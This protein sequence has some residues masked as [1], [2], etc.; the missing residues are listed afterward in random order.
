M[1]WQEKA[2]QEALTWCRTPY[3]SR[4]RIKGVGVDCGQILIAVYEAAGVLQPGECE[5]GDYIHDRHEH[6]TE[7]NYLEWITRY[8]EPI[9]GEP[10]P[11]DIAMFRYGHSNSHS[12]IVVKWPLVLHAYVRLGV[13]MSDINEAIFKDEHGQNRLQGV[14]RPRVCE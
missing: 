5:P 11:G 8:C 4:A 14:Y 12:A 3:H 2:V 9:T 7:E 10:Q 1:T 6:R 13:I